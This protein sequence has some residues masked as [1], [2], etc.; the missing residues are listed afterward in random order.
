MKFFGK[1]K[2]SEHKKS[3]LFVCVEN[4]ARSQ[5]A[6]GFFRKYSPKGYEP[7][8]AGTRPISRINPLAIEAMKEVGIDIS[9]QKSKMLTED[10]IKKSTLRVNMGCIEKGSCP[11]LFIHDMIDWNIEEKG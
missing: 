5:M 2:D 3:V 10:M 4:A 7:L 9:N 8:S 6:E 11:T 1:S